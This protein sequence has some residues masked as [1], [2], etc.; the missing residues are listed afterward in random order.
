MRQEPR[1]YSFLGENNI[2]AAADKDGTLQPALRQAEAEGYSAA[3][4][5]TALQKTAAIQS[6]Q[7]PRGGLGLP[8]LL[9]DRRLEYGITDAAFERQAV[10]DRVFLFQ[11][12]NKVKDSRYEGSKIVL[13]A[14]VQRR[15]QN[16]TPQAIIVSA[17]PRALDSL[18]SHGMGLGD[19]VEFVVS[20]PYHIRYDMI[21]GEPK[22]LIVVTVGDL[23]SSFDLA[24]RIRDRKVSVT[25]DAEAQ[26]HLVRYDGESHVPSNPW[27]AED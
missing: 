9:D 6:R 13:P 8:E 7:A 3:D 4:I 18:R 12:N 21:E 24:A 25:W 2:G 20:A 19:M 14:S 17:G 23:V 11:V 26:Q 1:L 22:H 10:F 15:E 27:R 5:Q 16:T